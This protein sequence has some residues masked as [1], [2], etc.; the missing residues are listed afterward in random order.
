MWLLPTLNNTQRQIIFVGVHTLLSRIPRRN[1]DLFFQ[2]AT[3]DPSLMF[4]KPGDSKRTHEA[5]EASPK[6]LRCT[7]RRPARHL[8]SEGRN[9]FF[10]RLSEIDVSTMR[11]KYIYIYI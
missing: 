1:M 7:K 5:Q 9:K 11:S 6:R 3:Y 10:L 2:K 4:L 8:A